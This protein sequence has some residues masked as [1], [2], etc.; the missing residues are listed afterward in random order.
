MKFRFRRTSEFRN[1]KDGRRFKQTIEAEEAE[2]RSSVKENFFL[3]PGHIY[4]SR[5][6]VVIS[7]VL[8]TCVSVCLWDKEKNYGGMNHFFYPY[9]DRASMTTTVFGNVATFLLVKMFRKGGSKIEDIEAQIFGGAHPEASIQLE[10]GRENVIQAKKV[11]KERKIK[12]VSEDVG[13]DR[14]RKIIF[15]TLAGH[16]A[17]VKV[18]KIR[19]RD[20][21]PYE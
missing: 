7:T 11:L 21:F 2:P 4:F 3:E 19:K 10:I 6:P 8:G 1:K 5:E 20:W 17:V 15:D 14:G 16:V 13:G 18:K 9:E 12:I